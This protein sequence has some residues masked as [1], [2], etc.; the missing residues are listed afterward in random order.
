MFNSRTTLAALAAAFL[1]I[2]ALAGAQQ[3]DSTKKDPPPPPPQVKVRTPSL[4]FSGVVFGNFDIHTDSATKAANGGNSTNK[5]DIERAYL[6]FEM[7]A[8]DRASVRVTTDIHQGA[9]SSSA[10]GYQ[11]WMVRLKYAYF[12]YQWMKPNA[13]G[14]G[15]FTRIGVVHTVMIDHNEHFWPRYI[16]KTA[17][18]RSGFFSSSD[19]GLA[20]DL[21]LPNQAGEIFG[22][23]TNGNG[24][25]HP[26]SNRFK[27]IALRLTLTPMAKKG[28]YW[29]TF[30][31]SPWFYLGQN[32]SAFANDPTNPVSSG[33]KRNRYGIFVGNK[34]P[35]FSWQVEW[36]QRQDE[37][38]S[39]TPLSRVVSSTT[40]K[41]V[42]GFVIV[43]PFQF[44]PDGAKQPHVGA[45]LRYD[46]FTPDN[47]AN[48]YSE[49]WI[50]GLF[51]EPT[52]KTGFSL[53]YQH[54]AP[55]NGLGG[56]ASSI[57]FLHWQVNF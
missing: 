16:S 45:L 54:V 10:G 9:A 23:I 14:V 5:F 26:E 55:K 19:V 46:H 48:G 43:R 25:E 8:G 36:A 52:P 35:R 44:G 32:A 4:K 33:L 38:D 15:F 29:K 40:G 27:D 3:K 2:P 34:D 20:A 13:Q 39:G 49:T 42:D 7:P 51:W 57:W 18:E 30:D 28:G 56:A 22:T 41:L 47:S 12:Q 24:Y 11:G 17:I 50:G 37:T 6:T 1:M 53:D 31:I 21:K